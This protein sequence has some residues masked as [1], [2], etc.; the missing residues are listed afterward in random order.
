MWD[1]AA[2]IT[3][4]D[5]ERDDGG[6]ASRAAQELYCRDRRG[7]EPSGPAGPASGAATDGAAAS[8]AART[9]MRV[10]MTFCPIFSFLPSA[11]SLPDPLS[12]FP[13]G[14]RASSCPR[15]GFR[16]RSFSAVK[17]AAPTMKI[18][19]PLSFRLSARGNQGLPS[20]L[21]FANLMFLL[22]AAQTAQSARLLLSP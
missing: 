16:A 14:F 5:D 22:L 4:R 15:R 21:L 19:R 1:M 18:L 7:A 6:G 17:R 13:L 11:F 3:D 10:I 20:L 12:P 9:A 8:A 2:S